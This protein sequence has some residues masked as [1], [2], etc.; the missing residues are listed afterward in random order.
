M[1]TNTLKYQKIKSDKQV[2]IKTWENLNPTLIAYK[3]TLLNGLRIIFIRQKLLY[4]QIRV[5]VFG[6]Q[7]LMEPKIRTNR[8][9]IVHLV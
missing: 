1:I 2:K 7:M 6:C 5:L 9:K 8:K 4:Q 3:R